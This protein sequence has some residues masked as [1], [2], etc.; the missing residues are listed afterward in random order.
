MKAGVLDL[1]ERISR[2]YVDSSACSPRRWRRCS[3]GAPARRGGDD[4]KLKSTGAPGSDTTK[5]FGLADP[6]GFWTAS[7]LSAVMRAST[8]RMTA[9]DPDYSENI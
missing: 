4:R 1:I 7:L 8:W 5:Y 6:D 2:Q 3:I 9:A